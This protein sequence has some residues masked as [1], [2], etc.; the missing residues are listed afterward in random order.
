MT[1]EDR[2]EREKEEMKELILAAASEIITEQG[3]DKLS[4]RKIAAK[5]EYS[6]A[7]IYHYFK[8]K[9]DIVDNVMKR[10]Y[11]KIINALSS[12]KVQT[13]EP[14][15]RLREL[16]RSYINAALQMPDEYKSVQMNTSPVMLHYTSSLF[17]GASQKKPALRVLYECLKDMNKDREIDDSNIEL[18]AQIIAVSTFGLIMK[19]IIEKDIGESQRQKLIDH[20]INIMVERMAMGGELK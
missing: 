8:D 7:I 14:V 9:N 19:L 18:T 4:V 10:G 20:Y 12:V 6:P 2:R 16:T 5:I 15:E 3:L 11:Q 13:D 1:I 17:E